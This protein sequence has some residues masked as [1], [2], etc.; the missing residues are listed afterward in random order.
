M[1]IGIT[2]LR[3]PELELLE[4]HVMQDAMLSSLSTPARFFEGSSIL[5][6]LNNWR[7]MTKWP[8]WTCVFCVI[9]ERNID[10][11]RFCN[12]FDHPY[13]VRCPTPCTES[14]WLPRFSLF[15]W[16]VFLLHRYKRRTFGCWGLLS[17]WNYSG[18][19]LYILVDIW[20]RSRL[21]S[22]GHSLHFWSVIWH[23]IRWAIK[24]GSIQGL[25]RYFCHISCEIAGQV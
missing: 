21:R 3:K 12:W 16:Q 19:W 24:L 10:S 2:H 8:L 14:I 11:G 13:L 23:V 17:Y 9:V 20:T 1:K 25:R 4:C 5:P 6:M 15:Y 22:A 18:H 7:C